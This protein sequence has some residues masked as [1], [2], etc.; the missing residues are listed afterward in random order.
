MIRSFL[1][2]TLRVLWRNKVTS[3]VNI[4]SLTIGITAFMF[5]ML[6][7][8]H[9]LSYDKFNEHYDRIYR[10][11]TEDYAKLPRA[12]GEYLKD[13]VPEIKNI[14]RLATGGK[15]YI[16][17][18]PERNPENQKHVEGI[19]F[20]A[21]S[22]TF[23][24]FTLPFLRGD[25]N[26]ALRDP[27]N[28]VLTERTAKRLFADSDPMGKHIEFE[29]LQ[30]TVT[31]IIRDVRNSHIEIDGLF[32]QEAMRKVYTNLNELGPGSP[33]WCATYFLMDP[34]VDKALIADK[35]NELKII[36]ALGLFDLQLKRFHIRPLK[37]IYFEGS[38]LNLQYGL[39]GNRKLIQAFFVIGIFM[40]VLACINYINL[41]TARSTIRA[42]EMAL[43]R[44]VGSSSFLLACQLILESIIISFVAFGVALTLLQLLLPTFNRM[45]MVDIHTSDF[46]YPIVFVGA[47][48]GVVLIGII[49]GAYPAV[50][51]VAVKPIGIMKGAGLR[52]SQGSLSRK[53]LMS[54]QFALSIILILGILANLRQMEYVRTA[55]LGFNKDH[56]IIV[57][58]PA[59]PKNTHEAFAEGAALRETLK[60]K[61]L[62]HP[63]ILGVS[64]SAGN[65]GEPLPI[66]NVEIEGIKTSMAFFCIDTDYLEVMGINILKGRNFSIDRP[67]ERDTDETFTFTNESPGILL[68]ETAVREFGIDSPIGKI[69]KYQ[70]IGGYEIQF[71]VIGIVEDF[72]FQSLHHKVQPFNMFWTL[73]MHT[74]NIKISS[75]DLPSTLKLIEKEWKSIYGSTP[76]AYRFLDEV[77]DKNY[78]S[79]ENLATVIGYFT[80]LAVLIACLGLFALSSFMVSRRTKEIGVRKSL[81]ASVKEIYFMLSWDFLKWIFLAVVVACPVAFYLITLW[82]EGFA[83][84]VDVGVDIFI[85]AALLAL[86]IALATVTW[87]SLKAA[88]ANPVKALRYE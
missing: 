29:S 76:F 32:P 26:T 62:Q 7:V 51:L 1:T 81:G 87:Q 56:I 52:D 54:F 18:I 13:K 84:H 74:A 16:S 39:R 19:F 3:F 57:N 61:L 60:K 85:M 36:Q 25:R 6:Y 45:A 27:F 43:K 83:Y 31:G 65:P 82:L 44:V 9:E 49:A 71:N 55:D 11:E 15:K 34:E 22:T 33:H 48:S 63:D 42:K 38:S 20:W 79:D 72:H 23:D 28:V 4:F 21:D 17:Y 50:Y 14:T 2:I 73:A 8:H 37:E 67:A 24:V 75:S 78:K 88:S 77:F 40:L 66:A 10:L 30:F 59:D 68:N 58:G 69:V 86:T 64:F 5:I 41:T 47:I 35:I 80:G 46:V 12:I 70:Y 53:I